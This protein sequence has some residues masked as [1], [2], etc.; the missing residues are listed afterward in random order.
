MADAYATEMTSELLFRRR[1]LTWL[2]EMETSNERESVMF[3]M[4]RYFSIASFVSIVIAAAFLALLNRQ[5]AIKAI[6]KL[7]E[8]SNLD[9]AQATLSSVKSELIDFLMSV[10]GVPRNE[11][12]RH[13]VNAKLQQSIENTMKDTMVVR[14]KIYNQKGIVV[15]STKSSQIGRDQNDNPGFISAVNGNVASKLIY[16]DTF[17]AFDKI[18]EED[19]L[20]QSYVPVRANASDAIWGV[21]EIYT[22][23]NPLVKRTDRSQVVI[24]IGESIIL[25]LLYSFLLF[26]VR[27]AEKIIKRQQDM[28]RERT[29]TLELLSSQLLTDQEN[30]KKQIAG[31][32]REGIA[33]TLSATKVHVENACRLI[34]ENASRQDA[35]PLESVVPLIQDAIQ[36]VRTIAMN[37][38]P[39]SLDDFGVL[40]TLSW[41][42]R[43]FQSI[44]PGIRIETL[45]NIQEKEVPGPLKVIIYRI[46]Q[47]ALNNKAKHG[48]VDF[49]RVD[50][51][52]IAGQIVLAIEDIG[53][54]KAS[55]QSKTER[56]SKMDKGAT[57]M[58]ERTVLSGGSFWV[59]NNQWGGTT[60]QASW[61]C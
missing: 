22:D 53:I 3:R 16:R 25:L 11:I 26:I 28:I 21:F 34:S 4:F 30:E 33:Q 1:F 58:E 7:G 56:D 27:R 55:Q 37:L 20:I 41:F 54:D 42:C 35:R 39:S 59:G 49:V 29:K 32:L 23:V 5:V 48:Q 51:S 43:E 57:S 6:T 12:L 2:G 38:R 24:M 60:S 36:E 44:H 46:V 9:L 18:T 40:A 17:N 52:K 45:L 14:I 10:E 13:P 47:D 15:F 8:Q 31:E 61:S 19:N 50:L